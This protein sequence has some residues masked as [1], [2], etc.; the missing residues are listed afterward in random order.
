MMQ[1][2][3]AAA[4]PAPAAAAARVSIGRALV[5]ARARVAINPTTALTRMAMI[6]YLNRR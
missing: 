5:P 6:N 3:A 1:P 4:A 2:P